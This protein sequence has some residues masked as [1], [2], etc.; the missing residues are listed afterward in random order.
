MTKRDLAADLAICE[1]L[2]IGYALLGHKAASGWPHA[3][4]RAMAAEAWQTRAV[5]VLRKYAIKKRGKF[6]DNGDYSER[7]M[8]RECQSVWPDGGQEFHHQGC[9]LAALLKEAGN[10]E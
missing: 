5:E 1:D 4:R 8:C 7:F 6:D 9:A 2:S 10:G 3:I